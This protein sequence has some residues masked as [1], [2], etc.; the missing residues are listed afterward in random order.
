MI[1]SEEMISVFET[2]GRPFWKDENPEKFD[3]NITVFFCNKFKKNEIIVG[4]SKDFEEDFFLSIPA[5]KMIKVII[6]DF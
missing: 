2:V 5:V 1:C 3:G 4:R 6:K